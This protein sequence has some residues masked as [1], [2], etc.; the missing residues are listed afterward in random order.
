MKRFDSFSGAKIALICEEKVV[1][2]LRDNKPSIPFPDH[3]D[4]AGGGRE[5]KETPEQCV[6]RE[7]E[8]EFD[9]KLDIARIVWRRRYPNASA[10]SE[11]AYF[12]VAQISK[13]EVSEIKFGKE[14]QFWRM[15]DIL[16]FLEH[17]KAVPQLKSRLACY[18]SRLQ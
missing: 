15:M 3:W 2:Y 17:P 10:P 9:L 1:T 6:L 5:G 7:T 4:L 16:E 18:M 12:M 14:G 11:H 8:E 13:T